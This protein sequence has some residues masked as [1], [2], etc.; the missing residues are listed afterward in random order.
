M[1]QVYNQA[2]KHKGGFFVENYSYQDVESKYVRRR[3][4]SGVEFK[5]QIVVSAL[6]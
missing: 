1:H 2:Y 4:L 3:N 6:F 5:S